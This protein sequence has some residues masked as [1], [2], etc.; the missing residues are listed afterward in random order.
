[1]DWLIDRQSVLGDRISDSDFGSKWIQKNLDP[2]ASPWLTAPSFSHFT[3]GSSSVGDL[4]SLACNTTIRLIEN[5]LYDLWTTYITIYLYLSIYGTYK[6][7]HVHLIVDWYHWHSMQMSM[8]LVNSVF[9]LYTHTSFLPFF[10]SQI[11]PPDVRSLQ[12]AAVQCCFQLYLSI[13]C[14]WIPKT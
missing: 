3:F 6:L 10:F 9:T 14:N 11:T 12:F 5:G 1:M 8:R 13:G 2:S 7:S 4:S